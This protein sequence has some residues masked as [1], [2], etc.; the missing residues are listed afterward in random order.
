MSGVLTP[1][2]DGCVEGLL[3]LF[4]QSEEFHLKWR[5]ALGLTLRWT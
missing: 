4:R 3:A 2:S 1:L 5:A